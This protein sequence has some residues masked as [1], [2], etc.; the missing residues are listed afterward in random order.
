MKTSDE[1]AIERVD[2]E[3]NPGN[4]SPDLDDQDES[5]DRSQRRHRTSSE[6]RAKRK[7]KRPVKQ[8][9]STT[10]GETNSEQKFTKNSRQP[11]NCITIGRGL[12]KKGD[13]YCL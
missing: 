4:E 3:G 8:Q 6:E 11:R 2:D 13:Y 7:A 5:F 1:K 12:P 9:S 10:N